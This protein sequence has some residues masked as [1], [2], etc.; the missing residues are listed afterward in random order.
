MMRLLLVRHGQSV[1]NAG[2]ILQGQADIPLSDLGREQAAALSDTVQGLRPQ[3]ILVSDLKRTRETAELLGFPEHEVE[4]GLREIDVGD[5]TGQYIDDLVAADVEAYQGWRA[6]TYT[7]PGGESWG[8]F[9]DRT[10]GVV[11]KLQRPAAGTVLMVA[12]GG[13][14]RALLE[15]LLDLSPAR[16]VPVGPASMTVLRLG[17][18]NGKADV[19]LEVFNYTPKA[20]VFDAPD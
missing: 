9:K 12:H 13:V 8:L 18:P 16:I 2:R 3:R 4:S 7:P 15:S 11:S 10:A 19:R 5:W 17:P 14:I 20:P 1:W 6:G